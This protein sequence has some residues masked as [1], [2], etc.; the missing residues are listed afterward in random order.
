MKFANDISPLSVSTKSS[1]FPKALILTSIYS[2]SLKGI[3]KDISLP[4]DDER[5]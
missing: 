4:R 2:T 3:I 1:F 5:L